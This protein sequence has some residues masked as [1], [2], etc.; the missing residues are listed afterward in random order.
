[1]VN[2]LVKIIYYIF[3]KIVNSNIKLK[4]IIKLKKIIV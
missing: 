2:E 4:I 3:G 1:M